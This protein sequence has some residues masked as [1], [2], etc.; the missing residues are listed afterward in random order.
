MGFT[1]RQ[2]DGGLDKVPLELSDVAGVLWLCGKR[3]VAPD[4]VAALQR[5]EHANAVV[6]F[7]ERLE[8]E[9][10]H[11][12]YAAWLD[13]NAPGEALWFPIPD[14]HAPEIDEALPVLETLAQRLCDGHALVLHCAGGMGRAPTMAIATMM[15]LGV[16][17]ADARSTVAHHRPG[18]GPEVGAQDALIRAVAR[19]C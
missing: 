16:P 5:A 10:E 1:Q 8:V 2:L 17:E 9:R 3:V 14:L 18:A 11:P 15:L 4:P 6:C 7:Q 19:H 13:A 12:Q